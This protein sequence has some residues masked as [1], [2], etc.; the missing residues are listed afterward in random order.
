MS[1]NLSKKPNEKLFEMKKRKN[2]V[3]Q[4]RFVKE[5]DVWY[6][7]MLHKQSEQEKKS[8]IVK[9]LPLPDVNLDKCNTLKECLDAIAK[10]RGSDWVGQIYVDIMAS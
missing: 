4:F 5:G 1:E 6:W 3:G 8:S 2:G 7:D 10:H 9:S